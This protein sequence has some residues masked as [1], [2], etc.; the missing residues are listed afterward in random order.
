MKKLL[1][2][3]LLASNVASAAPEHTFTITKNPAETLVIAGYQLYAD[4]V[5]LGS[6]MTTGVQVIDL[7]P[8]VGKT[9]AFSAKVI[10]DSGI[11]SDFSNTITK[12]LVKPG[13]PT[14]TV[15]FKGKFTTITI[16]P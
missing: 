12:V 6:A 11:E 4:G 16:N 5:A 1:L 3:M 7:S 8:Y 15:E 9:V 2:L 10:S 13:K 14:L